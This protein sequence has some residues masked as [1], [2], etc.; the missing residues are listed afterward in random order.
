MLQ[1]S[2]TGLQGK[3]GSSIVSNNS[4]KQ[5]GLTLKPLAALRF[6]GWERFKSYNMRE[7]QGMQNMGERHKFQFRD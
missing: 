2:G 3:S 1:F 5:R 6:T 7:L 4:K